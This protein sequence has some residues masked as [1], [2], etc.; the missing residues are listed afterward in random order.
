MKT[1]SLFHSAGPDNAK[2]RFP[3][4]I[5]DRATTN[6]LEMKIIELV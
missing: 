6:Q 5:I 3:N 2:A 4:F 1:G